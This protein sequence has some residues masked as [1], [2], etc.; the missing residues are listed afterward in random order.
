MNERRDAG[1]I[2]NRI[3]HQLKRRM[4][5]HE[6]EDS[7]T[8]MQRHVLHYVLLQS[9]SR[10]IYQKD[11]EAEFQIRRSTA[12]G[13]LQLL[14]K[15]GFITRKAED[16]D[17]RLKKIVPTEKAEKVRE[18]VLMNIDCTEKIIR[19][20]IPDEKME[21]CMDVLEQISANLFEDESCCMENKKEL[22]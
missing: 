16:R 5:C 11:I 9:L 1:K 22:E 13:I 20:G 2:I 8:N 12:T 21:I 3:S 17:A 18:H 4:N 14:E 7:L 10:D 15:N 19:R 6:E